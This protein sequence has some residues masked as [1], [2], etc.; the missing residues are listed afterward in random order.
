MCDVA[1]DQNHLAFGTPVL[2][3]RTLKSNVITMVTGLAGPTPKAFREVHL[4]NQV[5]SA[6][7]RAS[8]FSKQ[9]TF[10]PSTV[11]QQPKDHITSR[12]GSS[13]ARTRGCSKNITNNTK[14]IRDPDSEQ[15]D[16]LE[17]RRQRKKMKRAIMLPRVPPQNEYI[18]LGDER[19]APVIQANFA[20]V[21]GFSATNV[22]KNRLTQL[23]PLRSAGVFKKGR[24]S[25]KI[26]SKK[27][28]HFSES[29]L[30][31]ARKTLSS[32]FWQLEARIRNRKH[33]EQPRRNQTRKL[34]QLTS[35]VSE[36]L[37]ILKTLLSGI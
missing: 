37:T 6:S 24:A 1:I 22:G 16:R 17:E 7:L 8:K 27:E 26:I 9:D 15:I 4:H 20:L 32:P 2:K 19:K 18:K 31:N 13:L 21:H 35:T 36:F 14:Q 30:L 25:S 34:N 3:A 33:Q 29:K 10:P 28:I 11:N 5:T 12:K 23:N